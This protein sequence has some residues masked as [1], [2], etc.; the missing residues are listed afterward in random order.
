LALLA[1]VHDIGKV[2]I[3]DQ[4]LLKN[5][6]LNEE[7]W[8]I[9]R[10]HSEKGHRIASAS[11]DL[12]GIADFILKHHERWDGSGY[13]LGLKGKEIP[14]ECR[15]LAIVDAF[16]A[17]TSDRPYKEPRSI[18]DAIE[19]LKRCAG[20]QFDPELVTMFLSVLAEKTI[21]NE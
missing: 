17:M 19:E 6:P 14:V 5:G 3:P 10:K 4:I 13:P 15:I 20:S 2:G 12:L 1:Q 11:A 8:K 21:P 18:G 9:M 16:D 7:E